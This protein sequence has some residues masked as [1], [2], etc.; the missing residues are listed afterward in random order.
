MSTEWTE[1]YRFA[2]IF[3][4]KNWIRC[5]ADGPMSYA[6]VWV[7]DAARQGWIR[8]YSANHRGL[9]MDWFHCR[10]YIFME[11]LPVALLPDSDSVHFRCSMERD[12]LLMSVDIDDSMWSIAR[13]IE[14]EKTM[15]CGP[16]GSERYAKWKISINIRWCDDWNGDDLFMMASGACAMVSLFNSNVNICR[17]IAKM[18]WD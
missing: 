16:S 3:G 5:A 1:V 4:N 12:D 7:C 15:E 14:A 10:R 13:L 9:Y 8:H 11:L 17:K 2:N 6:Y 18:T